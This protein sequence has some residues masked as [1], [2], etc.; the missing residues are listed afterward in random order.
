MKVL[1]TA[2]VESDTALVNRVLKRV[3]G[4]QNVLV[5]NDEAHHV[6]DPDS[7]WN[8][9]LRFIHDTNRQRRGAGLVAQLD[10]TAT[11][12]TTPYVLDASTGQPQI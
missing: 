4:K 11:P 8:E 6:W 10:F 2:Y 9:A 7:A 12:N 3:G 5:L 1:G